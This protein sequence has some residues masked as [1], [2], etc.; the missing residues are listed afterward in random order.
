[1]GLHLLRSSHSYTPKKRTQRG[2]GSATKQIPEPSEQYATTFVELNHV[3]PHAAK[4][5]LR[6]D[7]S[8]RLFLFSHN[9]FSTTFGHSWSSGTPDTSKMTKEEENARHGWWN[10]VNVT[11]KDTDGMLEKIYP[12]TLRDRTLYENDHRVYSNKHGFLAP[13]ALGLVS[14][15]RSVRPLSAARHAAKIIMKLRR[16]DGEL[17]GQYATLNT[18]GTGLPQN[19]LNPGLY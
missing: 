9:A 4:E 3:Q 19:H 17:R 8:M 6:R 15:I 5:W 16:A 18:C 12:P 10:G 1:M 2:K 11:V 14:S 7:F 13:E